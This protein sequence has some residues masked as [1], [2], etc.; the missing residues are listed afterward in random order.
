VS[1][2]PDGQSASRHQDARAAEIEALAHDFV[3]FIEAFA[4]ALSEGHV[5]PAFAERL[6][7]L[8][9]SADRLI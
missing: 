8:R 2:A 4:T 3:A 7:Q 6:A 1:S 9:K 5:P